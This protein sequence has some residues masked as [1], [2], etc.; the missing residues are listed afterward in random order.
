MQRMLSDRKHQR[1]TSS[2]PSLDNQLPCTSR[3][4]KQG[5]E[6]F[7]TPHASTLL[8]R[9]E[10]FR[11]FRTLSVRP[12]GKFKT[13]SGLACPERQSKGRRTPREF[14]SVLRASRCCR[15]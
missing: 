9:T 2:R 4:L 11:S 14:F 5:S 10:F 8:S 1:E 15:R 7:E 12:F 3:A 13:A 6:C